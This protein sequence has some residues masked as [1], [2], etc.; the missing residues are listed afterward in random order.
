MAVDGRVNLCVGADFT[1]TRALGQPVASSRLILGAGVAGIYG[2]GTVPEARRRG[3]GAAMTHVPLL[4]ARALGYRIATLHPS[5]M[6]LGSYRRLGFEEYCFLDRYVLS[7][8]TGE[9][10]G[11]ARPSP[12]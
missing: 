10:A 3:I 5:P 12:P 9:T 6:G 4:Q 8:E 11:F 1:A 2:V 7:K